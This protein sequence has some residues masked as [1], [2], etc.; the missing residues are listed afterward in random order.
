MCVSGTFYLC[1]PEVLDFI[2]IFFSHVVSSISPHLFVFS[3]HPLPA[4]TSSQEGPFA[5][6][7]QG[8]L[9]HWLTIALSTPYFNQQSGAEDWTFLLGKR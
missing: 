7:A 5:R 8:W 3:L 4:Q 9:M 1:I 6:S 2:F